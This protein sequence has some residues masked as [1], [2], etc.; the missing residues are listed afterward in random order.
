MD[1]FRYLFFGPMVVAIF[2]LIAPNRVVG[3]CHV[4]MATPACTGMPVALSATCD[5]SCFNRYTFYVDNVRVNTTPIGGPYIEH[6]FTTPGQ[7]TITLEFWSEPEQ[8]MCGREWDAIV[9]NVTQGLSPTTITGPS[10]VCPGGTASFV[11]DNPQNGVTYGWGSVPHVSSPTGTSVSFSPVNQTT[12]FGV[13]GINAAGCRTSASKEVTVPTATRTPQIRATNYYHKEVLTST[14]TDFGY[15]WQTSATGQVM[16]LPNAIYEDYLVYETGDYWLRRNASSCWLPAVGPLHVVVDYAPPAAVLSQA[17]HRGYKTIGFG[18]ADRTHIFTYATYYWVNNAS[19]DPEI[20]EPFNE[21]QSVVGD[22]KFLD[23]TYYLKGRDNVTNTWGPTVVLNVQISLDDSETNFIHTRNYDGRI[24]TNGGQSAP[25]IVGESRVYVDQSGNKIQ[26]QTKSISNGRVLATQDISDR[27]ERVVGQ[28]HGAPIGYQFSYKENFMA[29]AKQD[30]YDYKKFDL[31]PDGVTAGNVL[32]PEALNDQIPGTLGWYYSENNDIETSVPKSKFPYARSD[33]YE[34][35]SGEP[36]KTGGLG[37]ALRFGARH[38]S[39]SGTFPVFNELN[40]YLVKR[41]LALPGITQRSSLLQRGV[42]TV[43]RDPHGKYLITITDKEGKA[44]MRAKSATEANDVLEVPTTIISSGD[45]TSANFRR[46][47]YFYLLEPQSVTIA[48]ANS[49][50]TFEDIVSNERKPAGQTFAKSDGKWPAGFYR[51]ILRKNSGQVSLSFVNRFRDIAYDFFD[52]AGKLRAAITPNGIE[53]LKAGVPYSKIDKRT[54]RYSFRGTLLESNE[55]DGGRVHYKSRRDGK[56][57]FSQ[58][59]LQKLNDS[60]NVS[61]KGKFSYSAYDQIGRVIQVGEYTGSFSFSDVNDQLELVD[62]DTFDLEDKTDWVTTVYDSPDPSIYKRTNLDSMVYR[63]NFVLGAVSYRRNANIQ[64]WYSYDELGRVAWVAQKPAA[65]DKVFVLTYVYDFLGNVLR[66]ASLA[67]DRSREVFSEF[68]HFYN[69]DKDGRLIEVQTAR[70][71]SGP[72]QLRA[73]YEYYLHGPLKRVELGD[74]LQGIDFVYNIQGWLTQINHPDVSQDPG[75]DGAAGSHSKF[76]KDVFGLLLSYYESEFSDVFKVS[77][78]NP[79]QQAPQDRDFQY[80]GIP[81]AIASLIKPAYMTRETVEQQSAA[82]AEHSIS[83]ELFREVLNHYI[84]DRKGAS[85]DYEADAVGNGEFMNGIVEPDRLVA[86]ADAEQVMPMLVDDRQ[87]NVDFG[88]PDTQTEE[89][90]WNNMTNGLTGAVS[91]SLVD[92]DGDASTIQIEIVKNASNGYGN[93]NFYNPDGPP[94]GTAYPD[95]ASSDSFFAYGPG[96]TYKLKGLTASK[97][98]TLTI[99]GSRASQTIPSRIGAYTINN[100]VKTLSAADNLNRTVS[101]HNIKPTP[102]GEII[103][104]FGVAPGSQ[105]GYINV[106]TLIEKAASGILKPSGLSSAVVNRQGV[107]SWTDNSLNETGFYI[108]RRKNGGAAFE[109]LDTVAANIAQYVDLAVSVGNSYEYRVQAFNQNEDSELSNT[110][111]LDVPGT[112]DRRF[113]VD[114]GNPAFETKEPG[115]NNMP[116]GATGSA[117]SDMVDSQG[118]VSGIGLEVIQ[119]ASATFSGDGVYYNTIGYNGSALGYPARACLDSYFAHGNGGSYKLTGLDVNKW[120]SITIFGSR[121]ASKND[122]TGQFTINGIRKLLDAMNN[123]TRTVTFHH[124]APNQNGEIVFDFGVD[125]NSYLGYMNVLDFVEVT[126]PIVATPATL[127]S[128]LVANGVSLSWGDLAVNETGYRVE[129]KMPEETLF[130]QIAELPPNTASFA[131]ATTLTGTAYQY[132]VCAIYGT[133]NSAYSNPIS[134]T[135]AGNPPDRRYLIDFGSPQYTT[136]SPGWNNVTSPLEG[137]TLANL[138]DSNGNSSPIGVQI[139]KVASNGFG[140]LNVYN[141]DG[142]VG[143]FNGYPES[144]CRDSYFAYGPGGTYKLKG[145]NPNRFY[146]ITIF[147]SRVSS[148]HD[149]TATF[150]INGKQYLLDAAGNTNRTITFYNLTPSAQ[151]ELELAFGVA[152]GSQLG[153]LGVM[154]INETGAPVVAAPSNLVATL[155]GRFANLSWTDNSSNESGFTIERRATGE[156]VFQVVKTVAANSNNYVDGLLASGTSYEYRLVSRLSAASSAYSNASG[157]SVPGE[158]P[159]RFLIDFG[160]PLTP[161][162]VLGWNNMTGGNTGAILSDMVDSKGQASPIDFEIVKN[163]SNNY[164]NDPTPFNT[165]GYTGQK[166]PQGYPVSATRDSY[167]AWAAGGVYK[168]KGLNPAYYYTI[169]IFASRQA[170][171]QRTG[172]YTIDG[173]KRTVN[174]ANNDSTLVTFKMVRP[175]RAGELMLDFNVETGSVLAYLNVMDF[176]EFSLP[177]L[178]APILENCQRLAGSA[179]VKLS[180]ADNTPYESA[181]EIYRSTTLGGIFTLLATTS[182]NVTSYT[183]AT[184][185]VNQIYYYRVR[186][187]RADGV[188]PYSN[189]LISE[190][191][192]EI[193]ILA[194]VANQVINVGGIKEVS[195][196]AIPGGNLSL[197]RKNIVILGSSTAEGYGANPAGN[198]W[199]NLLGK[200]LQGYEAGWNLI[201][202]AKFGYTTDSIVVTGNPQRNITKALSY[203]PLLVIINLPSNDIAAGITPQEFMSRLTTLKQAA[204]NAGARVL[205]TTTQPRS[206]LSLPQR[207][208]LQTLANTIKST[209]GAS[210]IDVFT[211][212]VNTSDLTILSTY[213]VDGIHVNNAGHGV[214]YQVVRPKVE[215]ILNKAELQIVTT[216]A[217]AFVKIVS[218]GTGEAKLVF[219]PSLLAHVGTYNNIVVSAVDK[220]GNYAERKFNLQVV[221]GDQA[222][223]SNFQLNPLYNGLVST[224]VWRTESPDSDE[225]LTGMYLYEYDQNYQMLN[226]NW[227]VPDFSEGSFQLKGNRYRLTGM[228]YDPNGNIRSLRRYDQ[229]ALTLNTFGY[230]YGYDN[231]VPGNRR[232]DNRLKRVSSY[233][234]EYDYDN[235]GRLIKED[236]QDGHNQY[237]DYDVMSRVVLVY[238]DSAKT[239]PKIKNLYDDRGFRLGK[240]VFPETYPDGDV[241][242]TWYIRTITGAIVSV[243]EQKGEPLVGD[244]DTLSLTEIPIYGASKLGVFYPQQDASTAYE[245]VDQLGNVRAIIRDNISVYA[246]TMEDS[247]VQEFANP[248]VE[249][250]QY[251]ENLFTTE[252][253]D[254]RMNHTQPMPGRISFPDKSAYLYWVDGMTNFEAADRAVGP[255]IALKVHAGDKISLKTWVRYQ[256]KVNY[257]ND[258]TMPLLAEFLGSDLATVL[259]RDGLSLLNPQGTLESALAGMNGAG[260]NNLVPRAFLN[261]VV[262]D[263]SWTSV[264][265]HK[266]QVSSS[267]GFEPGEENAPDAHE[268]LADSI[269]IPASGYV[270]I[271][272]SNGSEATKVWFDDLTVIHEGSIVTQA[273]DYGVWGDVLREKKSD[274]GTYR[275]GYQ[276]QYAEKDGETGWNHFELREY[277]P[278]IGRWTSIDPKRQF[279]SPYVGFGN[280]PTVFGDPDG[281]EANTDF[282]NTKTGERKHVEDGSNN[283]VTIDAEKW[284]EFMKWYD[285]SAAVMTNQQF[286]TKLLSNFGRTYAVDDF[287]RFY[288][289]QKNPES[290]EAGSML[291]IRNGAV[292]RGPEVFKG[293]GSFIVFDPTAFDD[294]V[295]KIHFHYSDGIE[296]APSPRDDLHRGKDVYNVVISKNNIYFYNRYQEVREPY[297]ILPIL[298]DTGLKDFT[299]PRN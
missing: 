42:Q 15:Y 248:R 152:A 138:K 264:A 180:W 275:F 281:G 225:P 162:N 272:V 114:F 66:S 151:G 170:V 36:R 39:L 123:S 169:N 84:A 211:P 13:S 205:I 271:W 213:N 178:D 72:R 181:Y 154:D 128:S 29:S 226:A 207:T 132:R 26:T 134:V 210:A 28:T 159:R 291:Y 163:A 122:R 223:A 106:L 288:K 146:S 153:Y 238:S 220:N 143:S 155:S 182:A 100:Q 267:A 22:R 149:K 20:I 38:E 107:L 25:V 198:S 251:F 270:Y 5:L 237:I 142:Y 108:D 12:T 168:L 141:A 62:Q 80:L 179:G 173:E 292:V 287:L 293:T 221:P 43:I 186:G 150:T 87:F 212:L 91:T 256:E 282:V 236:R 125:K 235:L 209:F 83:G 148:V 252:V 273:T 35:G 164:A 93:G 286:R 280:A 58:T 294:W 104:D 11:V 253:V 118:G 124:V 74:E 103:M 129:R 70:T 54:V 297:H 40:D 254:S 82:P 137:Y 61:D 172:S 283:V 176:T 126:D 120:Y 187:T 240:V 30:I 268:M 157:V 189:K 119:D 199:A 166:P 127:Q 34:D 247:E 255:S 52:D 133:I 112:P 229:S 102:G 299:I 278:I 274:E 175:N 64:T 284:G 7:H 258:L 98:Y 130:S 262:F 195:L 136:D 266:V 113:L 55:S 24:E 246:A 200:A 145:L 234:D 250:M 260:D 99:F 245:V 228:N 33:F 218:T 230:E 259:G 95:D 41:L 206:S 56:I 277:D 214:I 47:T 96:G 263:E 244:I 32:N 135:T 184:A 50:F 4:Q 31:P 77:S 101:F 177:E 203:N 85:S 71:D 265:S 204:E 279:Y 243:Y 14:G 65:L 67:Y 249:E 161:T 27:Y 233:V 156:S 75:N 92:S 190:N 23:G 171:D 63:Q 241:R 232:Y 115:W 86:S 276:G 73:R 3:Q 59:S 79:K 295:G 224:A 46:L 2:I 174:A 68:H 185:G 89:A 140:N 19:S 269:V 202:L 45:S 197:N 217:P 165:Q 48:S 188:T 147:G 144:A 139:V 97:Y 90:G 69:Y 9:V 285:R 76:K 216:N 8:V 257:T 117:L 44:I 116:S 110:T 222:P 298:K 167:F 261:Y 10:I 296:E 60:L 78:I 208:V 196:H 201:N 290:N 37:E 18:N 17:D 239:K 158:L 193:P 51:L 242:T 57:R 121:V 191:S 192:G 227:G 194:Q 105:F 131:D 183:D 109:R 219:E 215:A 160:D 88:N 21:G 53:A 1:K 6:T 289:E 94:T 81:D 111:L 231:A 49:N 16:G